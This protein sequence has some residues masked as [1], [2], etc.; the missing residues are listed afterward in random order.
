MRPPP[1]EHHSC[2]YPPFQSLRWNLLLN[3]LTKLI[4]HEQPKK[5]IN[6]HK[7]Y[8]SQRTYYLHKVTT[9]VTKQYGSPKGNT[10]SHF[11]MSQLYTP[12]CMHNTKK[13]Y[14][15]ISNQ[16]LTLNC[17]R[18]PYLNILQ[19]LLK[20]THMQFP[21]QFNCVLHLMPKPFP[22]LSSFTPLM[23]L[24]KSS[25]TIH[26]YKSMLN[27]YKSNYLAYALCNIIAKW[28]IVNMA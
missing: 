4:L 7:W 18:N 5:P 20:H 15:Q 9:L 11:I 6:T 21:Q 3:K 1:Q 25:Y 26:Q 10:P 2:L 13:N 23:R 14:G 22:I 24:S 27:Y 28:S 16:K 12:T 8:G 17:I 19:N